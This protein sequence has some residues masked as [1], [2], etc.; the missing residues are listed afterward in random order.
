MYKKDYFIALSSDLDRCK[1]IVKSLA[2][3][4]DTYGLIE[5]SHARYRKM[6][7]EW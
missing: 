1:S 2:K 7:T 6:V 4:K 5:P 3:K